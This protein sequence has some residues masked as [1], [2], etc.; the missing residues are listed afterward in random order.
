M[1]KHR[2]YRKSKKVTG[3]IY[4]LDSNNV[5]TTSDTNIVNTD[6]DININDIQE[7][8]NKIFKKGVTGKGLKII[9]K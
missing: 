5:N 9:P 3:K 8:L 4:F 7:K 1:N 2:L 6:G